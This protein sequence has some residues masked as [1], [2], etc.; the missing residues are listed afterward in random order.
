[1]IILASVHWRKINGINFSHYETFTNTCIC[2]L[3]IWL[4]HFKQNL[5]FGEHHSWTP[6]YNLHAVT[7]YLK[8]EKRIVIPIVSWSKYRDTYRIVRWAYRC[9]PTMKGRLGSRRISHPAGFEPTT[10]WSEV[11][12]A[13]RSAMRMLPAVL[14]KKIFENGGRRM[15]EG[16]WLYYKLTNE[17]KGSG[18]LKSVKYMYVDFWYQMWMTGT[19]L[20]PLAIGMFLPIYEPL[21]I[22]ID[23]MTCDVKREKWCQKLKLP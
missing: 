6:L 2:I 8:S 16:P 21:W 19:E 3:K 18:E 7:D 1:M 20:A 5:K 13:N 22:E 9:S 17:P 15:D 4:N 12:S 14:E 23:L 11:G 10:P